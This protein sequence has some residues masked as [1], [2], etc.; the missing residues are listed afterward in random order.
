MSERFNCFS[1]LQGNDLHRI[2]Q[3]CIHLWVLSSHFVI[4]CHSKEIRPQVTNL[5][6]PLVYWIK[7]YCVST[8]KCKDLKM[9][10][11]HVVLFS[12]IKSVRS[13]NTCCP[14]SYPVTCEV[15]QSSMSGNQGFKHPLIDW[16]IS[17]LCTVCLLI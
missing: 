14:I 13:S 16:L 12:S 11:C 2:K 9:V 8:E 6:L 3:P 4:C 7:L 10:L 5:S 1:E 15:G 17:S